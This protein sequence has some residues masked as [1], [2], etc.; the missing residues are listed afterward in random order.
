M[1]YARLARVLKDFRDN[2]REGEGRGRGRENREKE[3]SAGIG[4]EENP[5]G[6]AL[7]SRS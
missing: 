7:S 4:S 6:K 5:D 1:E 3:R 2:G